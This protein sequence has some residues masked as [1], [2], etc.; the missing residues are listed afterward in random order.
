MLISALIFGLL[1]SFHCIGMCGPI[2]FL[3]P[4]DRENNLKRLLQIFLYHSGRIFSYAVIGLAF[5]FVGKGLSLFGLQQQLSITIG[6]IMLLFVLI[7]KRK[8]G[9]LNPENAG[10]KFISN[11]KNHLGKELR[12]KKPDT[13]FTVGFLNGFLPCGLV[14][15][16][17]LGAIA[18][19]SALE[20]SLYMV[21]FG[22]GTIPLMTSAIWISNIISLKSR[23]YIRRFIPVFVGVIAIM[24]ILRGL[25]L[26]IP[27]V[28][29]K[30][31][32]EKVSSELECHQ[33]IQ[34]T[35]S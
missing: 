35:K 28:S 30:Q 6:V 32:T 5:G 29:P 13:F 14:Y 10:F 16:A 12:K 26:G 23:K 31:Q 9:R 17:V 1:G 3:L 21:L 15:M 4:L 8:L 22:V 25:G 11:L 34:I 20:G 27:Y 33:P 18:G 24:F 19:G 7:P 2:A